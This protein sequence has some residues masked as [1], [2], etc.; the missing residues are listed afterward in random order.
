[1]TWSPR[2]LAE[3][4]GTTRRTVRHYQEIG[5]L[6][7]PERQSNG[8]GLYDVDHLVRLLRIKR[9]GE[10]GLGLAQ[11]AALI[12]ADRHSVTQ[13]LHGLDADLTREVERLQHARRE[14][15]IMLRQAAP[16]ELPTE[17]AGRI[18]QLPAPEQAVFVLLSRLLSPEALE[19]HLAVWPAYRA[20]DVVDAFDRLTEETDEASRDTV[21]AGMAD[22]LLRLERSHAREIGLMDTGLDRGSVPA[23]RTVHEA[24]ATVYN[25]AQLEILAEAA[26]RHGRPRPEAFGRPRRPL[27]L[28]PGRT[29]TWL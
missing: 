5:L 27:E 22:H 7:E 17:V 24:M 10:L 25:P 28:A 9:L 6:P 21:A 13:A 4:A 3:L 19:A 29:L 1:M 8:Y 26:R 23:R 12:D 16:T 15:A 20:S 18:E 14:L 2:R 11:I